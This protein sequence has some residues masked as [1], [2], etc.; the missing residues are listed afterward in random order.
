MRADNLGTRTVLDKSTVEYVR[1]EGAPPEWTFRP[2]APRLLREPYIDTDSFEE[3]VH[4]INTLILDQHVASCPPRTY[5]KDMERWGKAVASDLNEK[6]LH[7][8]KQ[9]CPSDWTVEPFEY[10]RKTTAS[11]GGDVSTVSSYMIRLRWLK[12]GTEIHSLFGFAPNPS[13]SDIKNIT[14]P[15]GSKAPLAGP[16][17]Q[18]WLCP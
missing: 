10:A 5:P 6:V 3:V 14:L 16:N 18:A 13:N 2:H 12:R 11:G 17:A 15:Q 7:R 4:E 8:L 1:A 9:I